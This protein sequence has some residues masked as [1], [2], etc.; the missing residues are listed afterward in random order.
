M[1]TVRTGTAQIRTQ[2]L[3][4]SFSSLT[5]FLPNIM[6]SSSHPNISSFQFQAVFDA[7]LNEYS[8][9]TGKDIDS[10]PLTAQ[11]RSCRSASE[12]HGVLHGLA[13]DFDEF[14]N[15]GRKEQIM[16]KLK[17]TVDMLLTLSNGGA[18]GNGIGLVRA[19]V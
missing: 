18:L 5:I 12:V 8:R 7:A 14:R 10:D 9:K 1:C 19:R 3:W 2:T 11:L 17:P 16:G 6:A 15:G 4:L 13:Q